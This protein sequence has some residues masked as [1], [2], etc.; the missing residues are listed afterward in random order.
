MPQLLIYVSM[1]W[2]ALTVL[3]A[4]ISKWWRERK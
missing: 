4:R 3:F 1:A 2:I